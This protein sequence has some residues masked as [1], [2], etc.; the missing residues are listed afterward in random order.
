[1]KNKIISLANHF[2]FRGETQKADKI[3]S[4]I[5]KYSNKDV[6]PTME[7]LLEEEEWLKEEGIYSELNDDN[8]LLSGL[9]PEDRM[10]SEKYLGLESDPDFIRDD[11]EETTENMRSDIHEQLRNE[12][13]EFGDY[14]PQVDINSSQ[15]LLDYV[16]SDMIAKDEA[17]SD[18]SLLPYQRP[19]D[20]EASL[21]QDL[22]KLS[23]M[24]DEKG[25]MKLSDKVDYYLFKSA[26]NSDKKTPLH[27]LDQIIDDE[28]PS[29]F[30]RSLDDENHH[31]IDDD[32]EP[33][34]DE[35]KA[36][37]NDDEQIFYDCIMLL[38]EIAS[39][40]LTDLNE[41]KEKARK[42]LMDYDSLSAVDLMGMPKTES[43]WN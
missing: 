29:E 34:T 5:A 10:V 14:I 37:E 41:I 35:L 12:Y 20:I 38:D 16:N 30:D 42:I 39:N 24:L 2:D 7:Q 43:D 8:K 15:D 32:E 13:D 26:T 4:F 3:D 11:V 33:S 31:S 23:D 17:K 28:M 1:M 6:E 25:F 36:M 19:I 22:V 40:E 18:P 27:E 21:N 9:S